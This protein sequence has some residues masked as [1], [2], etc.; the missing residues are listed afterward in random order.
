[1]TRV[2]VP[3]GVSWALEICYRQ[4]VSRLI[5]HSASRLAPALLTSSK[6]ASI[7]FRRLG[8]LALRPQ[9]TKSHLSSKT[10]TRP[11]SYPPTRYEGLNEYLNGNSVSTPLP[12]VTCMRAWFG[13]WHGLPEDIVEGSLQG[14]PNDRNEKARAFKTKLKIKQREVALSMW[15]RISECG[16]GRHSLNSSIELSLSYTMTAP[17]AFPGALPFHYLSIVPY[18]E[19]FVKTH[20]YR[21]IESF[22]CIPIP[23][24][25]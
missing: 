2:E 25:Q 11:A 16:F 13:F 6:R 22:I 10:L 14:V 20:S 15:L 3:V 21:F 23:T 19:S 12:K 1:M 18:S 8:Q 4:S 7:E 17:I 24:F 5:Q 9:S